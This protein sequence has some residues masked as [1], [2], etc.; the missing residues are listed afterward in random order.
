[1][2]SWGH[3]PSPDV[4][5]GWLRMVLAMHFETLSNAWGLIVCLVISLVMVFLK[6]MMLSMSNECSLLRVEWAC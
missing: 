1:M 4:F 6:M 5:A 2:I 3:K